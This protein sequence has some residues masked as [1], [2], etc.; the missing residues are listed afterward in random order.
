MTDTLPPCNIE[1]EEALLGSLLISPQSAYEVVGMVQPDDFYVVKNGWIYRA[2]LD[3]LDRQD[4]VDL[5]TLTSDLENRDQLDE[6]GGSVYLA[7]LANRVPTAIHARSYAQIVQATA[8]RRRMISMAQDIAAWAYDEQTTV[9]EGVGKAQKAVSEVA[10]PGSAS[11]SKL[12]DIMVEYYDQVAEAH[13]NGG[14]VPGILTGYVD[15]DRLIGGWL[16]GNFYLVAARPSMGKTSLLLG[17]A[18][19]ASK[20]GHRVLL[21][22]VE[23]SDLAI[24]N[25]L[26]SAESGIDSTVLKFGRLNELDWPRFVEASGKVADWPVRVEYY[27]TVE[28]LKARC[29]ALRH[30]GELDILF[31]DYLQLMQGEGYNQNERV[32]HISSGLKS[33]ARELS[34]PVVVASQLSRA[35]ETR[36]DKRPILSDLRDSGSLEQDGDVVLFIYRDEVYNPDTELKNIADIIVA[37]HRD[38]PIGTVQ[39][40]F[41]KHLSQFVDA[42]IY[43]RPLVM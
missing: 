34:I 7:D 36:I 8:T 38:G 20:M 12:R 32:S 30:R 14:A 6:I 18:A 2:I 19:H 31:V 24:V 37:K 9:D 10:R 15:L 22:S 40:F 16:P 13:N 43:H 17:A 39:L 33:I 27:Y 41:R 1:A 26:V 11:R 42:E 25:R 4:G 35:C 23:M 28:S 21:D 5:V 29:R 3:L